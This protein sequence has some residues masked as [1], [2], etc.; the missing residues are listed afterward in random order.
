MF[1]GINGGAYSVSKPGTGLNLYV[2]LLALSGMGK[3]P[4]HRIHSLMTLACNTP[5]TKD[6][7]KFVRPSKA[8]SQAALAK[9]IAKNPCHVNVQGEW[10]R[11]LLEMSQAKS[12][13][14]LYGLMTLM[15]DLYQKSGPQ[16]I[17]GGRDYSDKDE[18]VHSVFGA[19]FSFLGEGTP[20]TF[21]DSLTD[22]MMADGFLSRWTVLECHDVK[23]PPFNADPLSMPTAELLRALQWMLQTALAQLGSP[24][25]VSCDAEADARLKAFRERCEVELNEAGRDERKRAPWTRARM[26]AYRIA[27]LLAVGS[28]FKDQ[29][30]PLEIRA[31]HVDWAIDLV[32]RN[33]EAI[34]LRDETG[35]I[36]SDDTSRVEIVRSVIN[37][38]FDKPVALS[39]HIPQGMRDDG[40][41][42][43]KYIYLR[44]KQ[45]A[46]F[47]VSENRG[48]L[49]LLAATIRH[50]VDEGFIMECDKNKLFDKYVTTSKA[51]RRTGR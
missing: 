4:M 48:T 44:A 34:T 9:V 45:K 25:H 42:T 46:A 8:V 27:G 17:V 26:K 19:A 36:G 1:A 51:Y 7:A 40:L 47:K 21:Y 33:V 24:V 18:I 39:Y 10:C 49:Q 16:S 12:T 11:T 38:Y 32:L 30:P 20:A 23:V 41:V 15:T 43:H 3:E 37:E 6:A 35:E 29:G 13:W 50:L 2:L 28:Y 22:S 14:P 31:E 5:E